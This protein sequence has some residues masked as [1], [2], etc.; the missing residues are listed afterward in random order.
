MFYG[1]SLLL[2]LT[3]PKPIV[4]LSRGL[5]IAGF[6]L[7]MVWLFI[8]CLRRLFPKTPSS[9]AGVWEPFHN[10]GVLVVKHL[11]STSLREAF[12]YSK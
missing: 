3:T 9:R 7:S 10:I 12:R 5:G 1:R 2:K 8:G 11:D 6:A 4:A